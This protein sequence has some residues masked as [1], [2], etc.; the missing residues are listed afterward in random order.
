MSD[1]F[2]IFDISS[3]YD[4]IRIFRDLMPRVELFYAAK[5]NSDVQIGKA[6]VKMN[7]GFDVASAAE[8]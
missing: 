1:S 2:Y 6:C 4:R 7:T 8:V 3:V 5:C